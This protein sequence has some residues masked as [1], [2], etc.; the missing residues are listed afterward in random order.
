MLKQT[1]MSI[2]A[3]IGS[4]PSLWRRAAGEARTKAHCLPVDGARAAIVGCGTSFHMATAYAAV[5]QDR[6]KGETHAYMASEYVDRGEDHLVLLSR[7]GTTSEIHHLARNAR[8]PRVSAITATEDAPLAATVPACAVLGYADEESV[9][10]TRFATTCLAL[11]LAGLGEDLSSHADEAEQALLLE[12]EEWALTA[13]R[14]VFLGA[15]WAYGLANEAALKLAEMSLSWAEAHN[16]FEFRHG[17]IALTERTTVLI[18]M[19]DEGMDVLKE[20]PASKGSV[21]PIP[22]ASPLARLVAA[23]RLGLALAR[24]KG[25]DP[26]NPEGLSRAVILDDT[27][28]AVRRARTPGSNQS[29]MATTPA[30]R[31][32]AT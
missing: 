19:A 22:S 3:E 29:Q 12:F 4:Q 25:L 21:L 1:L 23:Q 18:P 2:E 14:Y 30:R 16:P 28:L 26:A 10:Q 24:R 6:H 7:S 8:A 32:K 15:R 9:V 17:P 11:L 5:R 27:Q 20:S 13:R 31:G